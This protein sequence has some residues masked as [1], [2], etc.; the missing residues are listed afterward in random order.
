MIQ[1]KLV[2]EIFITFPK[3]FIIEKYVKLSFKNR[4]PPC[5]FLEVKR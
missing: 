2:D 4:A 1:Q 3:L 5:Y